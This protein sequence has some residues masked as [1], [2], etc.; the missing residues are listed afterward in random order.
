MEKS[1]IGR[2]VIIAVVRLYKYNYVGAIISRVVRPIHR[3]TSYEMKIR[4]EGL[5]CSQKGTVLKYSVR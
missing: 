3:K 1:W 4:K 2:R 5:S